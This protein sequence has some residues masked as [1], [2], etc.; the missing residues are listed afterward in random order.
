LSALLDEVDTSRASSDNANAKRLVKRLR[1]HQHD[2]FTFLDHADVASTNNFAEREIRPAVILRKNTHGNQSEQGAET[3]AILMSI[4]RTLRR[5][6]L[7][8]M[9]EIVRALRIYVQTGKLPP[10]PD[11]TAEIG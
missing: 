1:R 6:G 9:A 4:F 7:D 8:P 10:L 3:Q 11:G 5:R 2:M